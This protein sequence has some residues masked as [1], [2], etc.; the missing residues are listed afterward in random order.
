M[1]YPTFTATYLVGADLDPIRRSHYMKKAELLIVPTPSGNP[2]IRGCCSA[3]PEIRFA[4]V[5]NT[6]EN[7]SLMQF[8]FEKHVREAHVGEGADQSDFPSGEIAISP[9][10]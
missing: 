10:L 6:E 5:G 4:F 7:R 8:A 1:P 9:R 2:L 3:C